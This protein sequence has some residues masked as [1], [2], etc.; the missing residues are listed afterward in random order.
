MASYTRLIE[1]KVKDTELNRAVNKLSKTLDRIDKSLVG[2][3]KKLDHIAKQG[4]G[5]IAKEANKAEKSV[6]KLGK[7]L[8]SIYSA[9]GP[10]GIARMV[11]G[12]ILGTVLGKKGDIADAVVRVGAL[13][14]AIRLLT[15]G[16]TGL[17]ALQRRLVDTAT[18]LGGFTL[19]HGG[20]IAAVVGGSAAILTGTKFFY[21]F[22]KGVRQAEANMIDFIRTSRQVGLG[23]NLRSLFPKAAPGS[24]LGGADSLITASE[25]SIDGKA[26][27]EAA[28]LHGQSSRIQLESLRSRGQALTNNKK[29]QENLVALTGKHLQATI[30]VKRT[31][32]QYNLELAKT[33]LVQAAVTADI[34]GMQRAWQ[35]VVGVIKG[36]SGLL[37]GLFKGKF[38]GIGQAAGVI[39]LSRGIED[40]ITKI[41]L[42][43]KQW[44]ES[45]AQHAR[46]VARITEGFATVNIAYNGLSTALGATTWTINAIAGF[47][48]WEMEA[49]ESIWR[50]D[51]QI[52]SFSD[53]LNAMFLMMQGKGGTPGGVMNNL[54]DMVLGGEERKEK[55][56][57]AGQGPTDLQNLQRELGLI[58]TKLKQRN[59]TDKE[60]TKILKQ[61]R[62]VR[63]QVVK[64]ED[65]ILTKRIES[66]EFASKVYKEDYDNFRAASDKKRKDIRALEA[67]ERKARQKVQEAAAQQYEK[68]VKNY[69]DGLKDKENEAIK[70][71]KRIKQARIKLAKETASAQR[72]VERERQQEA[73]RFRENLMLGAG[74]PLLF[75]GGPG[76]VLGGVTGAA[77]S[78]GGK[79]FGAQ[80]LLSAFGQQIDNF[81][82][83]VR[84]LGEAFVK[85]TENIDALINA[86]GQK[87]T[88]IGDMAEQLKE[89][90][91]EANAAALL[92]NKFNNQFGTLTNQSMLE[93]GKESMELNNQLAILGTSIKLLTVG[94][95]TSFIKTINQGLIG[96]QTAVGN[97]HHFF[98]KGPGSRGG[99]RTKAVLDEQFEKITGQ[100]VKDLIDNKIPQSVL[101]SD[102]FKASVRRFLDEVADPGGAEGRK[103]SDFIMAESKR[104]TERA[105]GKEIADLEKKLALEKEKLNLTDK[106]YQ[107]KLKQLEIDKIAYEIETLSIEKNARTKLELD[108]KEIDNKIKKLKLTKD[109]TEAEKDNLEN[110][111]EINRLYEEIGGTIKN[112]IVDGIEAAVKGTKTL[113][114]VASQVLDQ[115]ARKLLESGVDKLFSSF[116]PKTELATQ[117]GPGPKQGNWLSRWFAG[118]GFGGGRGGPRRAAGG[119]VSGGKSYMVGEKGP[120]MFVPG[121][122]GNIVPNSGVGGMTINVDASG[123]SVEGDADK[124]RELGQLIG[125]AVQAEIGRQQRPG[126]ML[127]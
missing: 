56:R 12:G 58:E 8:K 86:V 1:F 44:A 124:S 100:K 53:G 97:V 3:D 14:G 101:E 48:K 57:F 95:L 9:S 5:G 27:H 122:R 69:Q 51:R 36:A 82:N 37:G 18:A 29:I 87:G 31:Q 33:R 63:N 13:D 114:E 71:E 77:L 85:P 127:Y 15:K 125:A 106:E 41:P 116:G 19:A 17:P 50:I 59:V 109:I 70:T 89:A 16:N 102:A 55:I 103:Q 4:F 62:I 83:K 34:W 67:Q 39:G 25:R 108:T 105:Q 23:K 92:L 104:L 2:I 28:T 43:N 84:E 52:K 20:A 66:G 10:P 38:G 119:P 30:Q 76:A 80:I 90:G 118:F 121:G 32:F 7:S 79:G 68:D 74:F 115:I 81:I 64:V 107:L 42:L 93:V 45:I 120:E 54:R 40:L 112:G 61:Q 91:L 21:D 98:D 6:G 60:Y 99:P 110:A 78:A 49:A 96:P 75:G 46:W 111:K 11:S 47:K 22:G 35:G 24:R 65:K 26:M 113:G 72:R 73:A 126:G 123:S 94:P 88:P 117:T